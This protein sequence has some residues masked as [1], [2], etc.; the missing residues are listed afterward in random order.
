MDDYNDTAFNHEQGSRARK[1]FAAV[2]LAALDD[3]ILDHKKFGNGPDVIERWA[4]SRDG[5][6]VLSCA[7]ID[8]NQRV[9]DGLK[10]FVERGFG[11]L[12][13]CHAKR[14]R[15]APRELERPDFGGI[16]VQS[17]RLPNSLGAYLSRITITPSF[18]ID[19]RRVALNQ[20]SRPSIA[21]NFRLNGNSGCS[22]NTSG[23]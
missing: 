7:G 11:H 14:A 8:P 15:D 2:V 3:A 22:S 19:C 16:A 9:V 12:L 10:A 13:H 1:L 18:V 4:R 17:W 21:L 6:E 5:R 20:P 23:L